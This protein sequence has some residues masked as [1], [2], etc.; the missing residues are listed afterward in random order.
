MWINSLNS[1]F[2]TGLFHH[3]SWLLGLST[4]C[5]VWN[6]VMSITFDQK[7]KK[8]QLKNCLLLSNHPYSLRKLLAATQ[9]HS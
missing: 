9:Q 1:T 4:L 3:W 6:P 7:I 2:N 8:N 5:S